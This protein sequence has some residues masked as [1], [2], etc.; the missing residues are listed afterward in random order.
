MRRRIV[1]GVIP[2]ARGLRMNRG[3]G[4]AGRPFHAKAD[5]HRP[6]LAGKL[7]IFARMLVLAAANRVHLAPDLASARH[8]TKDFRRGRTS[9]ARPGDGNPARSGAPRRGRGRGGAL[10]P[11]TPITMA[12]SAWRL[13]RDSLARRPPPGPGAQPPPAWRR[14]R[15]R[16]NLTRLGRRWN[17]E[18]AACRIDFKSL[19]SSGATTLRRLIR[20]GS[21]GMNG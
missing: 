10:A 13:A 15:S 6:V 5:A 8:I 9:E 21:C 4:V 12:K 1:Q 16:T 7:F 3:Q 18:G 19:S 17:P 20:R 2:F 14:W 11:V